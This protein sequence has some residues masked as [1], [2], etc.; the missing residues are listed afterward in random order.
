MSAKLA[1]DDMRVS[2]GVNVGESHDCFQHVVITRR[3]FLASR[4]FLVGVSEYAKRLLRPM[5]RMA[6]DAWTVNSDKRKWAYGNKLASRSVLEP[7]KV[8]LSCN[9]GRGYLCNPK[10][11]ADALERLYPGVFDLVL[12]VTKHDDSLP[13]YLR[14]VRYGSRQAQ[15]ELASARFWIYNF[16]DCRFVPKREGQVFIQAWHACLGA[17]KCE[18][19]VENVLGEKYVRLAKD[20]GAETDLMLADNRLT[21]TIYQDSFWFEGPVLRCGTPRN[22]PLVFGD[23]DVRA[24]VKDA[25]QI[26]ED[27]ALCL[28][29][30]TFRNDYSFDCYRF[31]YEGVVKALSERFGR[32]Y[33]L[34]YRLHP[35]M[36]SRPRPSF[37]TGLIDATNYPD[38]QELLV[39]AD[40]L[41]SDYSSIID[42]FCLTRKP[43]FVFAP[44]L[45]DYNDDR[46]LY[47]PL[48]ARPFPV[49]MSS[50]ELIDAIRAFRSEDLSQKIDDFFNMVGLDDDG[51]GDEAVAKIIYA[52]LDP[53]KSLN[54]VLQDETVWVRRPGA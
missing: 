12:L 8:V 37:L 17:K 30:P 46:G 25:L 51:C 16:R 53:E 7:Q 23:N 35:G 28:Y 41:I 52:L 40:V 49:A 15:R 21:A 45:D 19:D 2:N 39:A 24:R 20:D 38:Q 22:R 4:W 44:D 11:I 33:L 13:N 36:A 54:D 48:A 27:T 6:K 31:D 3:R 18:R 34:A 29:A 14:Q 9:F 47:Y 42:D 10:Y 5:L 50:S 26:P 1:F 32:R 43:G